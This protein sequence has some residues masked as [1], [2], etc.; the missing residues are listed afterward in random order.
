MTGV[1]AWISHEGAKGS[2]SEASQH[3]AS[4]T[5]VQF[6]IHKILFFVRVAFCWAGIPPAGVL[7]F[8]HARV[9]IPV[10]PDPLTALHCIRG[11]AFCKEGWQHREALFLPFFHWTIFSLSLSSHSLLFYRLA[12]NS[13]YSLSLLC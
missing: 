13:C 11:S 10:S 9:G 8:T 5:V 7:P 2:K 12:S 3:G 1:R 4:S 6:L